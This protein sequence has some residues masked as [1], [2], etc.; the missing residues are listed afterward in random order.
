VLFSPHLREFIEVHVEMAPIPNRD[1][2]GKD[3]TVN[4]KFYNGFDPKKQFWTDSNG[5]EMIKR[6]I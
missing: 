5:L 1:Q 6:E 4:F 2:N 3:V